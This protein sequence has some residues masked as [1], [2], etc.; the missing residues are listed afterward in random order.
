MARPSALLL[1]ALAA[2][3]CATPCLSDVTGATGSGDCMEYPCRQKWEKHTEG[4][5]CPT[6]FDDMVLD[7][8]VAPYLSA[9]GDPDSQSKKAV[10]HH[11]GEYVRNHDAADWATPAD[12][13]TSGGAPSGVGGYRN[14]WINRTHSDKAWRRDFPI[15]RYNN[16]KGIAFKRHG[17]VAFIADTGNNVIR[18]TKT[19]AHYSKT[20]CGPQPVGPDWLAAEAGFVDGRGTE[21]MFN[22]PE[23]VAF[24][25]S[26]RFALVAD[27]GNHVIRYI[28]TTLDSETTVSTVGGTYELDTTGECTAA[29]GPAACTGLAGQRDGLTR[30]AYDNGASE[31]GGTATFQS[32]KH[33]VFH[34]TGEYALVLDGTG[35]SFKIRKMVLWGSTTTITAADSTAE[36]KGISFFTSNFFTGQFALYSDSADNTIK[37]VDMDDETVT[38]EIDFLTAPTAIAIADTGTHGVIIDGNMVKGITMDPTG[39]NAH[40]IHDVVGHGTVPAYFVNY[41]M[42]QDIKLTDPLGI[43]IAPAPK[44]GDGLYAMLSDTG[45]HGIRYLDLCPRRGNAICGPGYYTYRQGKTDGPHTYVWPFDPE[46]AVQN[47]G[48]VPTSD[49]FDT[50][51]YTT[52]KYPQC[53]PCRPECDRYWSYETTPCTS[54]SD[55]VCTGITHKVRMTVEMETDPTTLD[56]DAEKKDFIDAVAE[57][58]SAEFVRAD[59]EGVSNVPEIEIR[60]IVGIPP[61]HLGR[62]QFSPWK[63][64]IEFDV[65]TLNQADAITVRDEL[66]TIDTLDEKILLKAS[67][68]KSVTLHHEPRLLSN[69]HECRKPDHRFGSHIRQTSP[70]SPVRNTTTCGGCTFATDWD[71]KSYRR[72]NVSNVNL[73]KNQFIYI[74]GNSELDDGYYHVSQMSTWALNRTGGDCS[75]DCVD[76]LDL[77]YP[78][79]DFL[80]IP[81]GI[82][83]NLPNVY[84][85]SLAGQGIQG[86]PVGSFDGLAPNATIDLRCTNITCVPKVLPDQTLILPEGLHPDDTCKLLEPSKYGKWCKGCEFFVNHVGRLSRGGQCRNTCQELDLRNSTYK[87]RELPYWPN[88]AFDSML[89]MKL[90]HLDSDLILRPARHFAYEDWKGHMLTIHQWPEE[91]WV[92]LRHWWKRR[93]PEIW[94]LHDALGHNP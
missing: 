11:A 85:L 20:A 89:G 92:F 74:E 38:T 9:D 28:D 14:S 22:A 26:E 10:K 33:V 56:E 3:M 91:S 79:M 32:P 66:W 46:W 31:P 62:S 8:T 29:E 83:D 48:D 4:V 12:W 59:W 64:L 86:V 72:R 15:E 71:T 43:A 50:T 53:K 17:L 75:S 87:I 16:P 57:T 93:L 41:T 47:G 35:S 5:Y 77:S 49:P 78:Q 19:R 76:M 82:F 44:G 6:G 1:A 39:G 18:S 60:D 63:I 73:T 68:S 58:V 51:V 27:T 81:K 52:Q 94:Y 30:G 2:S 67:F 13:V 24:H 36:L 70:G 55:R 88:G 65:Y 54:S 42:P 23:G 40:T 25:P 37:R 21:A 34:P 61:R 45:G 80:D 69:H 90:L 84:M 7:D